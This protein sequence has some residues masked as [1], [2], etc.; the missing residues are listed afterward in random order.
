MDIVWF[1]L[2]GMLV[3]VGI[4]GCFLPIL[5]GPPIA[6]VGLWIQQLKSV[7]PYTAQFLWM[8]AGI[9]LLVTVLD[10]WVPVYATKK[11]GGSKAG[12]IGC[13]L[14]LLAGLW[15]GPL[16]I[17]LGPMLG[18]FAGEVLANKNSTH[19]LRS[20]MGSFFGFLAGTILKLI[21]CSVMFWYWASSW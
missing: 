9:T 5:P 6:F 12:I 11:W 1:V 8:W 7:A 14:G 21:A 4:V 15:F 10:Y 20:A 13:A 18:A 17:I 2:G 16:G 3:L 19:A